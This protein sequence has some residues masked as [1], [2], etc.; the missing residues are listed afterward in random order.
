MDKK[1]NVL[2][3]LIAGLLV[4][5]VSIWSIKNLSFNGINHEQSKAWFDGSVTNK[6][7][8]NYDKKFPLKNEFT[9]FWAA[10]KYQFFREGKDGV[11]VGK[12]GWLFSSEEYLWN[13][14]VGSILSQN[15]NSIEDVARY[16]GSKGVSL[17]VLLVPEKIS[18]Y[19][20]YTPFISSHLRNDVD[21]QVERMLSDKGIEFLSLFEP[22]ALASTNE[23]VFMRTDTHWSPLGAKVSADYVAEQRTELVGQSEFETRQTGVEVFRGDLLNF[24]PLTPAFFGLGPDSDMLNK[25]TTTAK[26][27]T[28]QELDLFSDEVVGLALVGT[29]YSANRNWHFVDFL[30]QALSTELLNFSSEGK[31]PMTPMYQALEEGFIENYGITQV[32][33]EIPIRYLVADQPQPPSD[34]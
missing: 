13:E 33:W 22:L 17:V 3:S 12:D 16:L 23:L 32:L 5:L 7:E 10:L 31:G 20:Q 27:S 6:V 2:T 9:A 30:K 1:I 11:I 19:N 14:S 28:T 24:I 18:I 15:I 26:P 34:L 21:G 8:D 29:S 25:F 4:C